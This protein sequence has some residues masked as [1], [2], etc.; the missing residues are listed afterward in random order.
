MNINKYFDKIY[1]TTI[2]QNTERHDYIKN[3]FSKY[4][5]VNYEFFYG[6]EGEKLDVNK[7]LKEKKIHNNMSK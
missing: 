4:N 3:L 1:V 2:K 7:L 6:I 5:I